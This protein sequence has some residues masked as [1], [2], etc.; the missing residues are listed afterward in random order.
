MRGLPF[1]VRFLAILFYVMKNIIRS[2]SVYFEQKKQNLYFDF[3]KKDC[4]ALITKYQNESANFINNSKEHIIPK[5]IWV[6]WWQGL[7]EAPP[8]VKQCMNRFNSVPDFRVNVISKF[9]VNQFI[10]ISDVIE[11]LDKGCI[12]VQTLSDIVRIRLL[13]KF[14]GIYC[15]ASIYLVDIDFFDYIV[16]EFSFYSNRLYGYDSCVS[17]GLYSGFF[18][19]S[20]AG[21]PMFE[22]IDECMTY[23]IKKHRGIID[24]LQ[25]DYIIMLGYKYLPFVKN[26]VDSI[27]YNNQDIWWLNSMLNNPFNQTE[28]NKKI[29]ANKIF[30]ISIRKKISQNDNNIT[31]YYDY[32]LSN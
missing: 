17:Q 9:N 28:W 29:A 16:K 18:I 22:Y 2:K 13:R 24:Y 8:L 15:D 20:F 26:I 5:V 31:T 10:D 7:E 12:Y 14:G 19:A 6:F 25:V 21:N 3:L 1:H 32:L 27:P 4:S 11:L 30:K 23:F